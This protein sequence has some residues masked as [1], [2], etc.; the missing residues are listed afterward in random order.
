MVRIH[1]F[2]DGNGRTSRIVMNWILVKNKFPMFYIE[3][4]DR[5]KYYDAVERDRDN[6]EEIVNYITKVLMNSTH[7]NRKGVK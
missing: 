3:L 4:R 6:Y 7:S 1:P 5:I 2:A